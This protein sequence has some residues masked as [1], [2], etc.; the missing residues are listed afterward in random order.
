MGTLYLI[1]GDYITNS[2]GMDAVVN[3][4]NKYM[5]SG[6][7]ICG[8]IYIAAG[9]KLSEYCQNHYKKNMT[10]GEVRITPG[11]DLKA[12]IVHILVPKYYEETNPLDK[13]IYCYKNLLLSI[14]AKGYKKILIPSLGTGVYGYKHEEVAGPLI[15]LLL[16]FCHHNDVEIY[17]NNRTQAHTNIYLKYYNLLTK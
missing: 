8:A 4:Q 13:L 10:I 6:S 14:K 5:I 11:F 16:E 9:P 2:R 17:L 15:K 7:G 3:S 12:D 1:T